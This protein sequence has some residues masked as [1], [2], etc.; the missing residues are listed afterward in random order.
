MFFGKAWIRLIYLGLIFVT[1]P[2][3]DPDTCTTLEAQY[4]NTERG[5]YLKYDD[6]RRV[7]SHLFDHTNGVNPS[8]TLGYSIRLN[9]S[10]NERNGIARSLSVMPGDKI[11]MQVFGKYYDPNTPHTADAAAWST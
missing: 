11:D 2:Q 8:T 7:L 6:T 4:D 10:D 3:S 9:G 1:V 5:H